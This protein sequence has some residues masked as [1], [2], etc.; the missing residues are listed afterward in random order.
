[1]PEKETYS[2]IA[3]CGNC[4]HLVK[5][6]VDGVVIGPLKISIPKGL[7]VNEFFGEMPCPTCGCFYLVRRL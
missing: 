3:F 7:P 2:I 6:I 1:M 4:G 5:E